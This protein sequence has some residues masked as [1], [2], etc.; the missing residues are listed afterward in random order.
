MLGEMPV[1]SA[2]CQ[3]TDG[4]RVPAGQVSLRGYAMT[5]G[6]RSVPWVDVS[7]NGGENWVTAKLQE[8]NEPWAWR[9]WETLV[10]LDPGQ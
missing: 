3:P 2:I 5:G 1:N 6:D 7:I 9:F 4:E 10:D 8:G